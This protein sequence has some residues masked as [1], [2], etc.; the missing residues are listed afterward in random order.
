[1][2]WLVVAAVA[3]GLE[4][5]SLSFYLV[6]EGLAALAT[7]LVSLVFPQA[8]VQGLAFALF[9]LVSL[10]ILRPRTLAWLLRVRPAPTSFFPDVVG[11]RVTVVE[12]V[13]DHQ[14]MVRMGS[15]EFWSARAFPPGTQLEVG[16]EGEVVYR[17]GA[18][19]FVQRALPAAPPGAQAPGSP[20][21]REGP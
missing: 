5:L 13:T 2:V 15:G 14:G 4:L 1:M 11:R 19:L 3:F 6:Y 16:E 7:A 8:W 20:E 10:G 12:K 9:S 21:G 17:Q 18:R